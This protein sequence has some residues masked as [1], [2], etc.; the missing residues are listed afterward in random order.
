MGLFDIF[1]KHKE[2]KYEPYEERETRCDTCEY[3]LVCKPD[4]LDVTLVADCK[5][6]FTQG[7]NTKCIKDN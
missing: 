6:H 7:P 5:S 3:L 4:L 2:D 1:K